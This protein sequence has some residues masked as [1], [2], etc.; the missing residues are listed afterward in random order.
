ATD[1]D[2]TRVGGDAKTAI[3]TQINVVVARAITKGNKP[4]GRIFVA[5]NVAAKGLVADGRIIAAPRVTLKR[6]NADGRIL[7]ARGIDI[8]RSKTSG[9]VEVAFCIAKEGVKTDSRVELACRVVQKCL[10]AKGAVA[11]AVTCG[12]GKSLK[13]D[14]RTGTELLDAHRP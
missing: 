14:C 9:C 7:E 12:I 3:R 13:T 4:D 6:R 5:R 2:T 11:P 8:E 10:I 1:A